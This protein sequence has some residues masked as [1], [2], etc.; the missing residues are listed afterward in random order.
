MGIGPWRRRHHQHCAAGFEHHA[1]RDAL[2]CVALEDRSC[3]TEDDNIGVEGVG[4]LSDPGG[5]IVALDKA[6]LG[7][8]LG[9]LERYPDGFHGLAAALVEIPGHCFFAPLV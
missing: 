7:S 2:P 5:S 6:H 3:R 4:R 8:Y 1:C 9:S